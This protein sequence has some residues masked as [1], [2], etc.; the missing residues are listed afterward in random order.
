MF[1]HNCTQCTTWSRVSGSITIWAF[2]CAAWA[3]HEAVYEG[4]K[5]H[6]EVVVWSKAHVEDDM[7]A[8]QG[9]GNLDASARHA[10][11]FAGHQSD[12]IIQMGCSPIHQQGVLLCA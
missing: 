6:C 9:D 1:K 12:D 7:V 5:L 8:V 2:N 10:Y 11:L 3:F 4:I